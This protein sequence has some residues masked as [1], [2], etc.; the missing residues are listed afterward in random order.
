MNSDDEWIERLD[1]P[2]LSES[3]QFDL[4]MEADFNMQSDHKMAMREQED[5]TPSIEEFMEENVSSLK[6]HELEG[7]AAIQALMWYS[8][9]VAHETVIKEIYGEEHVERYLEE[10]I[11]LLTKRG[12]LYLWGQLDERHRERMIKALYKRYEKSAMEHTRITHRTYEEAEEANK[13]E[14][15]F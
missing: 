1:N 4:A 9:N 2:Q 5:C 13:G 7:A 12:I 3:E 10:K 15:P 14:P 8:Y 11:D 6:T